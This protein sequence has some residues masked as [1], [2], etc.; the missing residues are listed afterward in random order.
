MYRINHAYT[1]SVIPY[2]YLPQK[3]PKQRKL[4]GEKII[5]KTNLMEKKLSLKRKT[6]KFYV[7]KIKKCL[8]K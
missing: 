4:I 8:E 7:Q 2:T 6:E 5:P 1:A 3:F